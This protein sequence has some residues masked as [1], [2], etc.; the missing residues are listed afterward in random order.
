MAR[1]V[2][3]AR[4]FPAALSMLILAV[5]PGLRAQAPPRNAQSP[6]ASGA[7]AAPAAAPPEYPQTVD[8]FSAQISLAIA[9][10][11]KGDH[12]EGRRLL[13]QFRL[14]DSAKWF[15]EQFGPELG[16]TLSKLYD[17][18]FEN[19]LTTMENRLEDVASGKGRKLNMRLEPGTNRQP[20]RTAELSGFVPAKPPTCF[21]VFFLINLTGKAELVLK[22][23]YRATTWE[24]TYLYQ[25][26]AFRFVGRGAWPFWV[27]KISN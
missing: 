17:Q 14:A 15:A 7:V 9:A 19:Y 26:G 27:W 25:D 22:G 20:T 4:I 11:Q 5:P 13:E 3:W 23:N 8:G 10:Y 24:D 1:S 18:H 2:K 16:E 12:A 21:N 6:P